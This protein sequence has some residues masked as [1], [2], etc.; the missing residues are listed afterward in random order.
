MI[1]FVLVEPRHPGNIG[2]TAR[3]M[4]NFGI[5]ELALVKPRMPDRTRAARLAYGAWDIMDKLK[6]SEDLA[7]SLG[8]N[9]LNIA[10]SRKATRH[11]KMKR[12]ISTEMH[13]V[14]TLAPAG[15]DTNFVFG[16]EDNGLTNGE[17][18]LCSAIMEIPSSPDIPTLNLS[19]AAGILAYEIYKCQQSDIL[20]AGSTG[21]A[22]EGDLSHFTAKLDRVLDEAGYYLKGNKESIKMRIENIFKRAMP[23]REEARILTGIAAQIENYIK[24]I[25]KQK[26]DQ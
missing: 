19:H 10:V 25:K 3:I 12:F 6:V 26:A 21:S 18:A 23:D 8:Q 11:R 5:T 7:S 17:I 1:R 2:A 15:G 20:P 24:R 13:K 22:P 4:G 14:L 9:A 16:R